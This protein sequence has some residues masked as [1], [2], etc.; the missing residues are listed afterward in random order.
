MGN[1]LRYWSFIRSL[2]SAV[3]NCDNDDS[4]KLTRLVYYCTGMTRKIVE[5]C[6]VMDP[7][8]GYAIAKGLLK[9]RIAKAWI[10]KITE[11]KMIKAADRLQ[12]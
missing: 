8:V 11:N 5:L 6:A 2:E 10:N 1:P 3:D 7:L 12:L 9:D 4:A